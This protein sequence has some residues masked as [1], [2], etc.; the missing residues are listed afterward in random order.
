MVRLNEIE[1]RILLT[2]FEMDPEKKMTL[3]LKETVLKNFPD[4][5]R[6]VEDFIDK[7]ED[8]GMIKTPPKSFSF[9]FTPAGIEYCKQFFI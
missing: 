9:Q 5:T 6:L 3:I 7:M 8:H 2:M 4:D 1:K